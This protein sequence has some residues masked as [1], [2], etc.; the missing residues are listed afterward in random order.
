MNK[1]ELKGSLREIPFPQLLFQLWQEKKSG[2]L[3]LESQGLKKSLNLRRG[4]IFVE[5]SSFPQDEFMKYL[6]ETKIMDSS[7]AENSKIRMDKSDISF[8]RALQETGSLSPSQLWQ[9]ME[10]FFIRDLFS[11]FECPEGVFLLTQGTQTQEAHTLFMIPTLDL[12][13]QGIRRMKNQELIHAHLPSEEE[14]LKFINP[15]H[16][17][18]LRLEEPE[19]YLLNLIDGQRPLKAIYELSALER[20]ESE[21]II[22]SFLSVGLVVSSQKKRAENFSPQFSNLE[23]EKILES[24]NISFST[25]FKYI[26]K[27]L[28]PVAY[29]ILDKCLE[30]SRPYLSPLGKR[31]EIGSDGRIEKNS[32]LKPNF[33]GSEK[34]KTDLIRDLNEI[35]MAEV[36]VVKKILGNEHETSLIKN[37]EKIGEQN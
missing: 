35:L 31:I 17:N 30:E 14:S 9:L 28:G 12:I 4:N 18:S 7:A 36:L 34:V 11:L 6:V 25:V 19:L 20:K 22:F 24:F 8:F 13:L 1:G 29:N 2:E 23:L 26:S 15:P 32:L 27:E 16:F 5:K 10:I 33:M 37:L 3:E 21:K